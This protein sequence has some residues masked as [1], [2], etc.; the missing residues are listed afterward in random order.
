MSFS[1][2][3][4]AALCSLVCVCKVIGQVINYL[5]KLDGDRHAIKSDIGE[6]VDKIRAKIIIGRDGNLQRLA[7]TLSQG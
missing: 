6:D 4:D 3:T 2:A 5:E 7:E 1:P